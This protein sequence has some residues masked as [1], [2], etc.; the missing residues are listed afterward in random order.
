MKDKSDN[1]TIKKEHTFSLPMRLLAIGRTGCGKSST[2]LGNLLLRK[3]F[4]RNDF[5][6]E[7]IYVFSGS[8]KTTSILWLAYS[9][10][11]SRLKTV[12]QMVV[13]KS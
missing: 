6:P 7:N 5:K 13:F 10:H 3:E 9:G 2:A 8:L 4:Y 12:R 11:K 1:F